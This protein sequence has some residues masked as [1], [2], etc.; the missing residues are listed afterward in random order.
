VLNCS[1]ANVLGNSMF[2]CLTQLELEEHVPPAR[3]RRAGHY[4]SLHGAF[5]KEPEW[6]VLRCC[7][8]PPIKHVQACYT[9]KY[10]ADN[11]QSYT[12]CCWPP[13]QAWLIAVPYMLLATIVLMAA[14]QGQQQFSIDT[15]TLCK[16]CSRARGRLQEGLACVARSLC[17][18]PDD[19][20]VGIQLCV[21]WG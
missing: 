19:L 4:Y 16:Q 9:D 20:T 15:A 6:D 17:S 3:S 10:T 13:S 5:G 18:R 8:W 21:P 11:R 7:C 14:K 2:P 1:I 12:A